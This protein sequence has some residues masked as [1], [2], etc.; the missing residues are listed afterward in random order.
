MGKQP[1]I[2]H[3]DTKTTANPVKHDSSDYCRPTPKEE[4]CDGAKMGA[5]QKDRGAPIALGPIDGLSLHRRCGVPT[6]S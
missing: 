1:M 5:N 3:A 2:A 4:R 6:F